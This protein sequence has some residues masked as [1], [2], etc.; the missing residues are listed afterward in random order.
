[1]KFNNLKIGQRILFGFLL[2]L[3][4]FTGS[5]I[6]QLVKI[7]DLASLQNTGHDKAADA[8]VVQEAAA[9]GLKAY[10][11]IADVMIDR[12]FASANQNWQKLKSEINMDS[13]SLNDLSDMAKEK[14]WDNEVTVALNKDQINI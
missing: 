8:T 2:V 1:M 3:V 10:K 6:Y 12:D 4:I 5:T 9:N 7:N 13:Q 11:I 14:Q